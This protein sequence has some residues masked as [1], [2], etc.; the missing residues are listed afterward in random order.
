MKKFSAVIS[1]LLI[2]GLVYFSFYS[3]MPRS[4][5][6]A[7]IS[8]TKFSTQRAIVPLKEISK[9]PHYV[10]SAEHER[11]RLYL[12]DQLRA[13][14][15][16]VEEQSGFVLQTDGRSLV[17]PTNILARIP[18]SGS[19]KALLLLSHYDS[20]K[21]PSYGA[22]DAGSGVV[23]I[24]ESLRAYLAGGA[25][26]KNDIIILFSDSEELG[27]DGAVLFV[28]EHPW[29]KDVA[30]VLNFEA[31]GS[32]GPSNMILETNQGNANL[33]K[34]FAEAKPEY[35]V[36]SS[37]MY[38]IY[39]MLPNDTDSTVFRE[40]G[41]IDSFFFAFIDDHFD[42]HTANDTVENLNENTLQ[43][44]GSYLLPLLQYFADADLASLKSNQDHV[45]VNF[46]F[47]KLIHYPFSWILSMLLIAIA[48]FFILLFYGM[49]KGR[50][51]G[52]AIGKGFIALVVGLIACGVLGYF[53]WQLLLVLY[54][55]Y[56]EIQH[57]FTYNGHTY[58]AFFVLLSL[59]ILF[60]IYRKW[61]KK[62][63]AAGLFVAPLTIWLVINTVIFLY[64]K[65]A[66]YFIIPV[67]FALLS[68]WMLIKQERPHLLL[69][70]LLATPALFFFSPLIQF[71][72]VGLGLEMLVISCVF[73]VLTFGL[74]VP[75]F[76][77]YSK[78]RL[79][80]IVCLVVA[81]GFF[82]SAHLSSDFSETRQKPNSLVYYQNADD[83]TAYWVTYDH[84]L[85][86]WT[87]GYLGES[88]TEASTFISN[89]AGSKYNTGYSFAA[90]AP[91]KDIASFEIQ[92]KQDTLIGNE[93]NVSFTLVPKR[94][95]HQLLLFADTTHV[96]KKL[97]FNGKNVAPDSTGY[98]FGTRDHNGLL[99]YFLANNE[100]LE[101]SYVSNSPSVEFT[102][103]EYSYDLLEH[104]QFSIHK[105]TKNMM[106]KPFVVTDAIVVKRSFNID[107]LPARN[108]D[109]V[110]YQI[111]V[112]YE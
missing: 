37:L 7:T 63:E 88:P 21:V 20:A 23:T 38:S 75:V 1:L 6:S 74:L 57:G 24:L 31:R 19:G 73:T 55:Q 11:V 109:S 53:G 71:F 72:P 83:N 89:A 96:F 108:V 10:G 93:R 94:K 51:T 39:K 13:L 3:L 103:L 80:G 9:A 64:L 50:I 58:I 30:L 35:P 22:S 87:K 49:M 81:I 104:P 77:F 33:I 36:A 60:A 62:Q 5:T 106:P 112:P 54:P 111:Q 95:I 84:L 100:P 12:I 17:K 69:L 68:F 70:T 40:E 29:A 45:Y 98:A 28:K 2:L 44:Q 27:L 56:N 76:H 4:G 41:D 102:A 16:Q 25:T 85:D 59:A 105:R 78:K 90:E 61:G 34:A 46:P 91:E 42:Y 15:M 65:G 101:V 99:R 110:S 86:P 82:I 92:L 43:H 107:S 26:P 8:E 14:G 47:L 79:L 52:A 97:V 67:F 48:G 18:G 32:G 66:A